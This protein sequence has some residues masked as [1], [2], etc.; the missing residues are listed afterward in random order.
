MNKLLRLY[1]YIV[2]R[3]FFTSNKN[4]KNYKKPNLA[5]N[6][7]L[8]FL[9]S[10]QIQWKNGY[11]FWPV[12]VSRKILY[13]NFCGYHEPFLEKFIIKNVQE[14]SN[15]IDAGAQVGNISAILSKK[16]KKNG[17]VF[18]FEP[19]NENFEILKKNINLNKLINVKAYNCALGNKSGSAFF[20]KK[21]NTGLSQNIEK[22]G[23]EIKVETIDNIVKKKNLNNLKFI[24]IDVDGPDLNVL[25]GALTTIKRFKPIIVIEVSKYWKEFSNKPIDL[26][27]ILDSL[28]YKYF[29]SDRNSDFLSDKNI[30]KNFHLNKNFK[31]INVYC[32]KKN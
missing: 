12:M 16:I 24:K 23:K 13:V 21:T 10:F 26:F 14:G 1:I 28:N 4:S 31:A 22:I 32:I 30:K 15:C 2:L 27:K 5:G 9:P 7:I 18:S 6:Y 17:F 20:E 11:K 25:R 19:D 29:Y 8:K 3:L